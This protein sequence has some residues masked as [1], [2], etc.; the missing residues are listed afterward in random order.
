[1]QAYM[2]NGHNATQAAITA[3]YSAK[4][5]YSQGQRLLKHVETA[6]K[7]A[8]AAKRVSEITGLNA[9]RTIREAARISE[10]DPA[11]L[12]REDGATLKNI[13][14]MDDDTRAAIASFECE[15]SKVDGVVV[16]RTTKV[17]FW[18]KNRAID[19][20]M[21]HLGLFEKDNAQRGESLALQI[22]LVGK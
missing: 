13:A 11:R 16:T 1:M 19:M 17:K 10:V 3:G 9:E 15:E 8:E 20:G 21:K 4:T 5:A 2:A 18:D 14:E 22:V 7:L 6:G 12:F